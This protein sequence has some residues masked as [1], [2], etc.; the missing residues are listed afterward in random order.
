MVFTQLL[1]GVNNSMKVGLHE[2]GYDV[3]VVVARLGFGTEDVDHSD[4]VVVLEEL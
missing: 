4:D 1:P 2:L 3:N